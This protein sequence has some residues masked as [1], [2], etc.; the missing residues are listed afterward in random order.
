MTL[1]TRT[2]LFL[3]LLLL[4]LLMPAVALAQD[5]DEQTITEVNAHF[6]KGAQHF[7]DEEWKDAISEFEAGHRKIP[8]AIFLYNISLAYNRMGDQEKALEYAVAADDMGGL[9]EADQT[10][11]QARIAA[12]TNANQAKSAA[13]DISNRAKVGDPLF[14]FSLLGWI[15]SGLVVGGVIAYAGV[16][17]IDNAIAPDVAAYKEAV[18]ENDTANVERLR[19]EIKPKQNGGRALFVVGTAA[20]VGG[21][22][23][24]VY[25]LVF[26]P[27]N[28]ARETTVGF[29]P[30]KDGGFVSFRTTF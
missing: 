9:G 18:A 16:L 30:T 25:D 15:G 11:N 29:A 3:P 21:I 14:N 5:Y 6:E 26:N 28:S 10:Q 8:N 17:S 4:A 2:Y 24:I 19:G 22:G 23:L 7:Y 1:V 12:L 27:N 13:V 20:I